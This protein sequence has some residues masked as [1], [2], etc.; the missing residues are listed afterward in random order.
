M[1]LPAMVAVLMLL[2]LTTVSMAQGARPAPVAAVPPRT[3]P[4]ASDECETSF[5][6]GSVMADTSHSTAVWRV[7]GAASG[8]LFSIAGVGGSA[9]VASVS[10]PSPSQVPSS[11]VSNCFRNGY[12]T[13]ARSR[14]RSTAI[15]SAL[16]GAVILPTVWLLRANSR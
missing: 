8:L 3:A 14:N 11:E 15:K 9:L 5:Q 4:V 1:F 13:R 6:H 7:G 12:R 10:A 16:V 2:G